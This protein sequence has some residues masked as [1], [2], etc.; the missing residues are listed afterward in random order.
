M[1]QASA[2]VIHQNLGGFAA[3]TSGV[4]M[5][6][7]G[8]LKGE[9]KRLFSAASSLTTVRIPANGASDPYHTCIRT[10]LLFT[11]SARGTLFSSECPRISYERTQRLLNHLTNDQLPSPEVLRSGDQFR[12]LLIVERSTDQFKVHFISSLTVISWR[13]QRFSD[14]SRVLWISCSK[15]DFLDGACC[16]VCRVHHLL[17][18]LAPLYVVLQRGPGELTPLYFILTYTSFQVTLQ[19]SKS[20]IRHLNN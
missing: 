20:C 18:L 12:G 1:Q 14:Q 8:V 13:V 3:M 17:L 4:F 5:L 10:V 7:T 9:K 2:T 19:K 16:P 11:W 6:L 15:V